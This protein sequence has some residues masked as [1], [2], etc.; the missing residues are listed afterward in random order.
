MRKMAR[1]NLAYR[2]EERWQDYQAKPIPLPRP[3]LRTIEGQGR[4]VRVQPAVAPWAKTLVVMCAVVFVTLATV[5]IARVSIANAT[6]QMLQAAE[7]TNTAI[8]QARAEGLELE[9]RHALANN[10]TRIQ[11]LAAALGILPASS[12]ETLAAQHGFSISTINQMRAAAEEARAAELAALQ[13]AQNAHTVQ[14]PSGADAVLMP[15]PRINQI[16]PY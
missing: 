9:V 11:D 13:E 15:A 10:P 12:V 8:I 2:Q 14:V 4:G 6:V 7:Q 5:S 1:T 3:A 16:Q